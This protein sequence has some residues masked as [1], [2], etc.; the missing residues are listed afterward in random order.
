MSLD[1]VGRYSKDECLKACFALRQFHF[2]V[3]R[4]YP[5]L[6][7]DRGERLANIWILISVLK[8]SLPQPELPCLY[9]TPPDFEF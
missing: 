5:T 2:G 9:L 6:D 3:A 4:G 7:L 1:G 8:L